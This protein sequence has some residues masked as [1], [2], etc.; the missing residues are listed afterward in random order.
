MWRGITISGFLGMFSE[1][2]TM[3]TKS[4]T[5]TQIFRLINKTTDDYY[6]NFHN[7]IYVLRSATVIVTEVVSNRTTYKNL[8]CNEFDISIANRDF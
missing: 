3:F 6:K 5:S 2:T 4:D 1:R 7:A 8:F